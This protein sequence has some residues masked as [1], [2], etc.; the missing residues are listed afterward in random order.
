M[1]GASDLVQFKITGPAV[2]VAVDNADNASHELF[3]AT[4]RHAYQGRSVAIVRA[5][6]SG[7]I[8][9]SASAKGLAGGTVQIGR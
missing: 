3:Q 2:I 9:V 6:G 4:S 1:P 8:T 7:R 5:T